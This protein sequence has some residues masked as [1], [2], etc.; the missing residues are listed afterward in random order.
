V[1]HISEVLGVKD[2][3]IVTQELFVSGGGPGGGAMPTGI[4]PRFAG[5]LAL[6][7]VDLP[8]RLFEIPELA[9]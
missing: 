3:D 2:G 6:E 8:D 5:R 7:G 1:A 4:R 9:P